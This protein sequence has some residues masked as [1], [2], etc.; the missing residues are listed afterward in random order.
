MHAEP[1][2][3]VFSNLRWTFVCQRPQHLPSGLAARRRVVLIKEPLSEHSTAPYWERDVP[4]S[5]VRVCKP[6]GFSDACK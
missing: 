2:L 6:A 1:A 5:N 4:E 3:V